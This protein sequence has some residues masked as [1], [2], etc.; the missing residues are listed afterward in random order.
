MVSDGSIS[1]GWCSSSTAARGE[2]RASTLPRIASRYSPT[3]GYSL[4]AWSMRSDQSI[5]VILGLL[6][7][8]DRRAGPINRAVGAG[9]GEVA[10]FRVVAVVVFFALVQFFDG[11]ETGA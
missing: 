9:W 3:S 5:S 7:C 8:S 1:T 11:S 10:A 2:A 4:M 6:N